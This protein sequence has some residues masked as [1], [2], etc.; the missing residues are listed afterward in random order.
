MLRQVVVPVLLCSLAWPLA[1]AEPVAEPV[2]FDGAA[3]RA[4][5]GHLGA[6]N[7]RAGMLDALEQG[8]PIAGKTRGEVH[9]L[10]GLPDLRERRAEHYALGD[11][12]DC[13]DYVVDYDSANHA[14]GARRL[15]D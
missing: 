8:H 12:G 10:L 6:G 9:A 2:D 15:C 11:A 14:V 3:W 4:A 7:P 13:T 1:A 5:K